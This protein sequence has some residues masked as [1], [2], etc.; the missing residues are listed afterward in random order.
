[1][2]DFDLSPLIAYAA[3]KLAAPPRYHASNAVQC[4]GEPLSRILWLGLDWA[5]TVYGIEAR[6]CTYTIAASRLGENW[7]LHMSEKEWVDLVDFAE[8]LRIARH[9]HRRSAATRGSAAR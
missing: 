5:V 9:R 8:A 1:M 4:R 7:I 6:D 3:T 2:A